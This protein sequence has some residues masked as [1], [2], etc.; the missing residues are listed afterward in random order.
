MILVLQI[1]GGVA[2]A[3]LFT[4]GLQFLYVGF[5]RRRAAAAQQAQLKNLAVAFER[6]QQQQEEQN[7]EAPVTADAS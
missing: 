5:R 6:Y 2:L 3:N 1:A 7:V 4:V